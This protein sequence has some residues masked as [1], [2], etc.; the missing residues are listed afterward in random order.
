MRV[1]SVLNSKGG[2]GKTTLTANIGVGLARLG[3]RVLLLD[4]DP[5]TNLT[6]S[7]YSTEEWDKELRPN[8]TIKQW[9]DAQ[10]TDIASV[11][12][13]SKLTT[14][15]TRVAERLKGGDGRLDLLPSHLGLTEM[16]LRLSRELHSDAS[17]RGWA[18]RLRLHRILADAL[19]DDDVAEYDYVLIDCAPDFGLVTRIAVVASDFLL[20]PAKADHLSVLGVGHLLANIR[21]LTDDYRS[22]GSTVRPISPHVLGVAFI[23]VQIY[24]GQPIVSQRSVINTLTKAVNVPIFSAFVRNSPKAASNAVLAGIPAILMESDEAEIS[25][26][27][28]TLTAEFL[29]RVESE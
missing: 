24:S 21:D 3:H 23:M 8:R 27:L 18:H 15:P 9:F 22:F 12:R 26:D 10:L 28:S 29:R 25:A 14:T 6:F 16:D 11:P 1:V 19:E 17:A 4:L 20:V 2:V 5:Q 13:L 7:F